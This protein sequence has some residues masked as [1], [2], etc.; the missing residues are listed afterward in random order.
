[1]P[2]PNNYNLP[3]ELTG[4][5]SPRGPW[6]S[7]VTEAISDQVT[8][9]I[10]TGYSARKELVL[11]YTGYD[12][13][14]KDLSPI[15]NPFSNE[16][17]ERSE[18]SIAYFL[19]KHIQRGIVDAVPGVFQPEWGIFQDMRHEFGQTHKLSPELVIVPWPMPHNL[20]IEEIAEH[21]LNGESL[22]FAGFPNMI[23]ISS[24]LSRE[25]KLD[26]HNII[27]SLTDKFTTLHEAGVS[28]LMI[29]IPSTNTNSKVIKPEQALILFDKIEG[30]KKENTFFIKPSWGSS[31]GRNVIKVTVEDSQISVETKCP[32]AMEILKSINYEFVSL[33]CLVTLSTKK[34][35]THEMFM[36]WQNLSQSDKAD[37][38]CS[39]IKGIPSRIVEREIPAVTY[40][41]QKFEARLILQDI[42]F[43][44]RRAD[45]PCQYKIEGT[46]GKISPM[47]ITTNISQGASAI[48]IEE[49]LEE[50][51]KGCFP[52]LGADEIELKISILLEETNAVA[53]EIARR[54]SLWNKHV[55]TSLGLH[56]YWM[57]GAASHGL[58]DIALDFSFMIDPEKPNSLKPCFVEAGVTYEFSGLNYIDIVSASNVFQNSKEI[59]ANI[60]LKDIT[61]WDF[62][63]ATMLSPHNIN[64]G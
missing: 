1:M 45:E 10:I 54:L 64:I 37:L 46:Y 53:L 51:F 14:K 60:Y 32:N 55:R 57:N 34:N 33:P 50:C 49:A 21:I 29:A 8:G 15:T 52:D 4:V 2:T 44:T 28:M 48:K 36:T 17:I 19:G 9:R 26:R 11:S 24:L 18:W 35:K 5:N 22:L 56:S 13:E 6:N 59:N 16:G 62:Y 30:G 7:L 43:I 58:P 41:D 12:S 63:K 61:A 27:K 42:D 31:Q 3:F 23:D 39:V 47:S 40:K 38:L 25:E 20:P